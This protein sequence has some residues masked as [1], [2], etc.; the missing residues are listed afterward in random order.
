[1][2]LIFLKNKGYLSSDCSIIQMEV[3]LIDDNIEITEMISFFLKTQDISCKVV[4]DGK[5]AIDQIKNGK[6][7][8]ILLD[9][10]LP[11]FSGYDI[12]NYLKQNELLKQ[13]NIILFTA[14]NLTEEDIQNMIKNGAKD[15]LKKPISIDTIVETIKKY[16]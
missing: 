15:V 6:Y 7:N 8:A 3:L 2:L 12:F 5:E 1:M 4:N 10:T 14:S 9:L 13:N 11:I 16:K